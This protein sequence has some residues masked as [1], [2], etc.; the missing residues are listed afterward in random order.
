MGKSPKVKKWGSSGAEAP[1]L[2]HKGPKN[3]RDRT[4]C[5]PGK[6]VYGTPNAS[7]FTGKGLNEERKSVQ[8]NPGI[9]REAGKRKPNT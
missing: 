8:K 2:P 4:P 3:A 1:E 5:S 9:R 6:S 7:L